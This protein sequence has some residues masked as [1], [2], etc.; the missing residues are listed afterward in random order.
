MDIGLQVISTFVIPCLTRNPVTLGMG[1]GSPT[2]NHFLLFVQ[3]K[4]TRQRRKR[5]LH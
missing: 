1:R 5:I 4:E 2:P 3:K